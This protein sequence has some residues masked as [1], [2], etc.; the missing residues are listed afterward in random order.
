MLLETLFQGSRADKM[1]QYARMLDGTIPIFSQFGRS[2]Y[3]SDIVQN[4]IDVIATEIS[5]LRPRHIRRD[6]NGLVIRLKGDNLNRIFKFKPNP[7][8]TTR[9]FLEKVT[10]LLYLNYNAFIYP[11]FQTVTGAQG[12]YRVYTGFYPLNPTQV[13]FLRTLPIRF[14]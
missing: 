14:S 2:I 3:A 1:V 5:K 4:C 7:L 9:D 11:I 13:E 12:P 8:M 6:E 10:W